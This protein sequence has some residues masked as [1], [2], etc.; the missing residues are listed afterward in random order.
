M[1]PRRRIRTSPTCAVR[2]RAWHASM[3]PATFSWIR[4]VGRSTTASTGSSRARRRASP[5]RRV[6]GRAHGVLVGRRRPA[7][8]RPTTRRPCV[9]SAARRPPN[10][11]SA[12][13]L[14]RLPSG[15]ARWATRAWRLGSAVPDDSVSNRPNMRPASPSRRQEP[16]ASM[17]APARGSPARW[18]AGGDRSC[19]PGWA[20]EP[21]SRRRAHPPARRLRPGPGDRGQAGGLR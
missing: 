15:T 6:R 19:S 14:T 3:P 20:S 17:R 2:L 7:T 12:P 1:Q 9:P 16:P 5:K 13:G 4:T 18:P 10:A 8:T 11:R 21:S